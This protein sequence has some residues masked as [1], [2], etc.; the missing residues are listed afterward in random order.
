MER[1]RRRHTRSIRG[2]TLVELIVVI[3]IVGILGAIALPRFFD[4]RTFVERGYYE[5]LVAAIRFAQ[6]TAVA[7]GCPV[8]MTVAAGGYTAGQQTASAGR[9]DPG[10][11]SYAVPVTLAD[12]QALAG[13]APSG[14]TAAPPLTFTFDTLGRTDLGADT[15]IT[16]GP[17]NMTVQAA[18]GYVDT[19]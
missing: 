3:I 14:V 8:R 11:A 5:E 2:F 16:V 17:F 1:D 19:P 7:S 15:T 4:D 12:G 10:D 18:S 6:K 9:C 13:T